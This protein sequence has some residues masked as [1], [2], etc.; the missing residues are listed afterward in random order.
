MPYSSALFKEIRNCF[1]IFW[2]Y[3]KHFAEIF[4]ACFNFLEMLKYFSHAM[5]IVHTAFQNK[6][7]G[8]VNV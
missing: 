7:T 5:Y 3:S 1:E 2:T 4:W 8:P 6:H